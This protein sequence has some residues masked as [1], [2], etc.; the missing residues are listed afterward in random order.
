VSW[1]T[2]EQYFAEKQSSGGSILRRDKDNES[3]YRP[4]AVAFIHVPQPWLNDCV[5]VS[6]GLGANA[7][8]DLSL[9]PGLT[10]RMGRVANL[11]FGYHIGTIKTK[12]PG[13]EIGKPL[14]DPAVLG[15]P[16]TKTTAKPFFA[17]TY[18]FLGKPS[19]TVQKP[20]ATPETNGEAK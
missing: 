15:N 20:F 19:E 7:D 3:D 1:L 13:T 10:L 16:G 18:S 14:D 2:D 12:P 4:L 17:F 9:L 11:T 8:A 5:S 6:L